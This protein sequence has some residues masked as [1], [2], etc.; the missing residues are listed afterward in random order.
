MENEIVTGNVFDKYHTGNVLYQKL[1]H[2][3]H[4]N[5]LSHINKSGAKNILEIGCGEGYL[6]KV[7]ED[8]IDGLQYTGFDI[9]EELVAFASQNMPA[10][11]FTVGDVYNLEPYLELKYDL[12]IVSEV[13]EHLEYPEKALNQMC[14]L[15]SS[16]F[17]FTVPWEP[18]WRMLNL[19]RL[20]YVKDFGNTPGHLQH[21]N[22]M[23]FKK[24]ISK[25]FNV[26]QTFI[27]F[28]W[29]FCSASK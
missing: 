14:Q 17:L 28:P 24:F 10:H 3:F 1:M 20:S 13:M 16:Q 25:T 12:V 5:L 22:K 27:V 7:L 18:V 9:D 11:T 4:Q 19:A 15:N 29:I 2:Q 21:W 8:N 26:Q 23:S 6:A